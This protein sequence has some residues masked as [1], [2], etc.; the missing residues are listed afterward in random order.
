[1]VQQ[2]PFP[3][4]TECP[5]GACTCDRERLLEDPAGDLR[6]L[7]LT[8]EEEKRLIARIEAIAT[9]DELRRLTGKLQ[10]MVGIDLQITPSVHGVRTVRGLTIRLAERPGLCR[11]LRQSIPAAVRRCLDRKPDIVYAMLDAHGLLAD[12]GLATSDAAG[13]A[14][15]PDL[16]S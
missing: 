7:K 15:A 11:K 14:G 3:I 2:L 8:R 5:P 9:Y 1:M 6:V 12:P 16:L 4:R 10:D 13:D